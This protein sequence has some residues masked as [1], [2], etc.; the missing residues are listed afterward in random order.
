MHYMF[1]SYETFLCTLH[2]QLLLK[3][4]YII[5]F[6]IVYCI[7]YSFLEIHRQFAIEVRALSTFITGDV[8]IHC[9]SSRNK[10][11][12]YKT[13]T[14]VIKIDIAEVSDVT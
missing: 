11:V 10:S 3:T 6:Y 14:Q 12:R 7:T 1:A 2:L 9:Y 5:E 8:I 4:M 13:Y